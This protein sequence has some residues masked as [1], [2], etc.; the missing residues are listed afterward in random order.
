MV[1]V[2][3]PSPE[4][5]GM[6]YAAECGQIVGDATKGWSFISPAMWAPHRR[7]EREVWDGRAVGA[8]RARV[9]L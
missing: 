1:A 3:S 2:Q 6:P 7:G 4:L 9:V 5:T 8:H